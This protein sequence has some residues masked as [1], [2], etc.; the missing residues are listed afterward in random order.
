MPLSESPSNSFGSCGEPHSHAVTGYGS[1]MKILRG[2]ALLSVVAL[3]SSCGGG[4]G[5]SASNA[6]SDFCDYLSTLEDIDP[7]AAPDDALAAID[8]IIDR[9]PDGEIKGAL[10]DLRPIFESMVNIDPNN[11][12]AFTEM[13]SL[14]FDPKVI[15]AGE[16]LEK[17][18]TEVCGFEDT[19]GDSS[20]DTG[21]DWTTDADFGQ[22]PASALEELESSDISDAVERVLVDLAPDAYVASSGWSSMGSSFSVDVDVTGAEN[23]DGVPL[24]DAVGE[25]LTDT[26]SSAK[27]TI[28]ITLDG[29]PI[30]RGDSESGNCESVSG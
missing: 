19:S 21:G 27:F 20:V 3:A 28:S 11:E 16:V 29:T 6:D 30:A 2:L 18:G 10:E 14:M 8:Q 17:Y 25:L 22:E 5:E 1:F 9:A 23:I 26:D 24:C 15:A 7:E 4:D 12:E 13:M